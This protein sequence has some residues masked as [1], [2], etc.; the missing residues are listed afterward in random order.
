MVLPRNPWPRADGSVGKASDCHGDGAFDDFALYCVFDG[1]N[2]VL[3][4]QYMSDTLL[5]RL[6][7]KLP[8]GVPPSHSGPEFKT[9]RQGIVRALAEV[10]SEI[11]LSFAKLGQLAGCTVTAVLQTGW[12]VT[13]ANLG[14]SRAVV[15]N[16]ETV[17]PLTV[18][19][20]VATNQS[21]RRRVEGNGALIAPVC[22]SG[23]GPAK[24]VNNGVGP[25]RIW[26]GGV[27]LSRG[28]GDFDVGSVIVPWPHVTQVMI[29]PSGA[30]VMLATDG[31][32]DAFDHLSR[33]F[34][35]S[36]NWSVDVVPQRMIS[37]IVR[38][39][40]GLRDDTSL[41]VVD[42]MPP[43]RDFTRNNK[44]AMANASTNGAKQGCFCLSKPKVEDTPAAAPEPAFTI[45]PIETLVQQDVAA[46]LGQMQETMAAG[47]PVVGPPAAWVDE[48]LKSLFLENHALAF[49]TWKRAAMEG[50]LDVTPRQSLTPPY[51][52]SGGLPQPGVPVENPEDLTVRAGASAY[53]AAALRG[54]SPSPP[55]SGHGVGIASAPSA[56]PPASTV[57][58]APATAPATGRRPPANPAD[59]SVRAGDMFSTLAASPAPAARRHT[60]GEASTR[61]GRNVATDADDYA[62]RFGAYKGDDTVHMSGMTTSAE[63]K[64]IGTAP[65]RASPPDDSAHGDDLAARALAQ[66]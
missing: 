55:P 54:A 14:D 40:G 43:G 34:K 25:L 13:C 58:S 2:G 17:V 27:C 45:G 51:I 44:R 38:A 5:S 11:H 61:F 39:H 46:V 62:R 60:V 52:A 48:D 65:K 30:R 24:D 42:I 36:R 12:L 31:V 64:N 4:A 23:I 35:L 10:L 29:P 1:H 41:I 28:I 59:F 15:D 8:Q 56:S 37:S 21:E 66:H 22:A 50:A 63:H 20:R 32:W 26:P 7:Q 16:G 49:E 47:E 6:V 53:A 9:W 18:D 3:A 19:H 57:G 33:V